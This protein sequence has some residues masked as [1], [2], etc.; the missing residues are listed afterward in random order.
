MENK[1]TWW[2]VTQVAVV[3][4]EMSKAEIEKMKSQSSWLLFHVYKDSFGVDCLIFENRSRAEICFS[5]RA[6]RHLEN[7]S[8]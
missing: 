4:R 6:R 1:E 3:P 7:C 5:E 2:E 8:S